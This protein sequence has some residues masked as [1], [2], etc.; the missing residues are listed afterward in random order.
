MI[1]NEGRGQ[2]RWGGVSGPRRLKGGTGDAV[3]SCCEGR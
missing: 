1:K 2:G 3:N